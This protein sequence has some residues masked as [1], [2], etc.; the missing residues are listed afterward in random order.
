MKG[1][2]NMRCFFPE[3]FWRKQWD[4]MNVDGVSEFF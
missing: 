1:G 2:D 3:L 4:K